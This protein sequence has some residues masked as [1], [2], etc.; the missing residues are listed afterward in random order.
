[1]KEELLVS[2]VQN[3]QCF[4]KQ[5]CEVTHTLCL[6]LHHQ[7][8]LSSSILF[9]DYN[10]SSNI[11]SAVPALLNEALPVI[12]KNI[13]KELSVSQSLAWKYTAVLEKLTDSESQPEEC[14]MPT[15]LLKQSLY[16]IRQHEAFLKMLLV[17]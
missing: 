5:V 16:N 17:R 3:K 8:R 15:V 6:Q 14:D 13:E 4:F 9:N 2:P 7:T 11:P 1:M 12:S 10:T